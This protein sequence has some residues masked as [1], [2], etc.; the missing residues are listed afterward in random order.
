MKAA[1]KIAVGLG[2]LALLLLRVDAAAV[3]RTMWTARPADL[4]A[5]AACFAAA[6]LCE[7]LKLH[8][9][10][11]REFPFR[12][13]AR[14]VFIGLF[15]NT[16]LP[17]NLGGDA[18][19]IFAIRRRSDHLGQAVLP[20]ALDRAT[21][22]L[23]LFL[24]GLACAAWVGPDLLR[25]AA[26][27]PGSITLT[28]RPAV[29]WAVAAGVALAGG[30][31]A[32]LWVRLPGLAARV[33]T[34]LGQLRSA[35]RDVRPGALAGLTAGSVGYHAG[36]VFGLSYFLH[37]LGAHVPWPMLV[38]VLVGVGVVSTLPVS[39]GA[40]GVRE[41]ALTA[42]LGLCGVPAPLA[43]AVALLNLTVLWVKA[44]AGGIVLLVP[45]APQRAR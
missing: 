16:F 8:A 26:G 4:A 45:P 21:G 14:V 40:L 10:V 22:T 5:G 17:A 24:A 20:V 2:L 36:R 13:T 39:V 9:L 34:L 41:G 19:R 15:Y 11:G 12:A 42:L 7:V 27:G 35:W 18:Y 6:A 31:L 37:A 38:L 3:W 33:R 25:G 1:L 28:A 30:V 29:L 44:V 32:A 43:L 23:V